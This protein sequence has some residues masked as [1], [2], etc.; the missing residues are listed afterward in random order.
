MFGSPN[1]NNLIILAIGNQFGHGGHIGHLFG[2]FVKYL[3][4]VLHS[5]VGVVVFFRLSNEHSGKF[6]VALNKKI[7]YFQILLAILG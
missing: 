6:S 4:S 7:W 1:D 2:I 3:R 5:H